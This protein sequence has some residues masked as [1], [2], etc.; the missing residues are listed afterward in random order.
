MVPP[1]SPEVPGPDRGYNPGEEGNPPP[2]PV[3][4]PKAHLF[5]F[6]FASQMHLH[7]TNLA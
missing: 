4:I 3:V 6:K 5:V 7:A 2:G 1:G